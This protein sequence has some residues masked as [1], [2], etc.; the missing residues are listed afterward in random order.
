MAQLNYSIQFFSI[1][2]KVFKLEVLMVD[3]EELIAGV[4]LAAGDVFVSRPS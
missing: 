3:L 1:K 2:Q 4:T